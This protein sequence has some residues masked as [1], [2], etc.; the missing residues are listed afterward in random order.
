M[1]V[2]RPEFWVQF[3]QNIIPLQNVTTISFIRKLLSMNSVSNKLQA[4]VSAIALIVTGAI[5]LPATA[6]SSD[7][8]LDTITV[9]AQKREQNI[10]D[11]PISVATKSGDELKTLFSAGDDILA[12]ATRIPSL[13]AETSNGRAAPRFYIRGLG[14]TDFDLAAS[15]PVSVIIDDVVMENVILKSTPLF[16][17]AQVEVLRGPQGTLFGRNTPAGIVKFDT[18]KPSQEF[19]SY[20]TA[21][22]GRFNTRSLEGAIGG[23]LVEDKVSFRLSGLYQGRDDWIN[24]GFTGET[25]ALGGYKELA[26]RAQLLFTPTGNFEALANVH[27]RDLDGTSSIFRANILTTGSNQ[28]NSNFNRGAVFFDEGNGNPQSYT[29][30]GGSLRMKWDNDAVTVTSISAYETTKGTS[31]GD[32]DGGFGASFLPIMGPGFI[33]FPS[34]TQDGIDFLNQYTQEFRIASNDAGPMNWQVGFYFFDSEFQITTNPFF[35]AAS[36]VVHSNTA[37]SFFG[38]SSYQVSDRFTVT[39]GLRYTD[40]EKDLAV[41]ASPI[42]Q[43]PVSVSDSRLSWDVSGLYELSDTTNLYGRIASGFRAPTIQGRDVAFFGSPSV[44]S[45]EKILSFETGFKSELADNRLR[46]N[47]ALFYYQ[48]DDMQLSAIGGGANFVR[49]INADKGVGYGFETD[50]EWLASD[51]LLITAGF[52]YNHTELQDSALTTAPC[53]SGQCTVLDPLDANGNA[54]LDGNPFPQAPKVIANFTARYSVPYGE[55][56]EFFVH[57]DWALQ[58]ST[59]I[60][61]YESAEYNSS[62]NFEGGLKLGYA[63]TDGSME[64]ALVGRNITDEKNLKGGVD[65]NNLTGITNEPSFYGITLSVRR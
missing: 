64:V 8:T 14:N 18:V 27:F 17:I 4:S 15:Q 2:D 41:L 60:F 25:D 35:I 58:G 36:T 48:V 28:L 31:L 47:G 32:I 65:F 29:G 19:S 34:V 63:K 44:A 51:N 33:P 5:A 26:G 43:A 7:G 55:T 10:R 62:G 1:F 12:L 46:V 59:N 30:S 23:G 38:Q 16:D 37:W 13:Y 49:L 21:N 42:P 24:N 57:T 22:F 52:S 6:Q 40:D 50:I 53:G 11:V 39:G 54:I 56:G 20:L 9:T 61:L 3:S 45:S